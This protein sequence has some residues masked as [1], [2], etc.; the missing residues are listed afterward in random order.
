MAPLKGELKPITV[1]AWMFAF[2]I[3]SCTSFVNYPSISTRALIWFCTNTINTAT[4]Q[5]MT[6]KQY[7]KSTVVFFNSIFFSD[8]KQCKEMRILNEHLLFTNWRANRILIQNESF[9]TRAFFWCNTYTKFTRVRTFWNTST[10][11]S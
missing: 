7:Y 10:I 3:T 2:G 4:Y 6:D 1:K 11:R 8:E 5:I 9:W